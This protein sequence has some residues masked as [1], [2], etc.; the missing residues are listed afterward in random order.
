MKAYRLF[1]LILLTVVTFNAAAYEAGIAKVV[2]TPQDKI[3]MAG[4]AA[5]NHPAEG[6][7]HDLYAKALTLKDDEGSMVTMVTIDLLGVTSEMTQAISTQVE[8]KTGMPASNLML[9]SSH[10][11]SGP[12]VRKNLND[13]Y[14]L[15]D[16]QKTLIASYTDTLIKNI[17]QAVLQSQQ[18]LQPV[19]L[20]YGTGEAT[21]AINRREY[22]LQGVRI[23]LNPIAPVDH[24]VPVLSIQNSDGKVIGMVFGYACHNTTMD[25]YQ[26]CG[27]YAGFAQLELER[28]YPDATAMFWS[29]C[30]GDANPNPRRELDHA[31]SHGREL[32]VA[33]ASVLNAPMKNLDGSLQVNSSTIDLQLTPA[34]SR[35]EIEQQRESSNKYIQSRARNLLQTLVSKGSISET[36]PYP[37]Q[38]WKIG[39]LTWVALAGEVVVDYALRFKHEYGRETTWVIAYANDVFAYIPSLRVLR[40]GGYESETSMIYYGLHGP[41]AETVEQSIVDEV[42]QLVSE[43]NSKPSQKQ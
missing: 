14:D 29:G 3:W 15:S 25:F 11:H 6:V 20:S 22:T 33:V 1:P 24:D 10:T 39:E 28:L 5:R 32:A 9:T 41:W 18:N 27:D 31:K 21:F 19:S 12:V 35:E 38:V 23:G 17:I 30:G 42:D 36:Y 13:M 40:E 7:E 16:E 37:I 4:Y 34:P 43:I 8:E 26:Y 2:I